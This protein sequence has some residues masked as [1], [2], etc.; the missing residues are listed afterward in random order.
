MPC[1]P[2]LRQP[3]KALPLLLALLLSSSLLCSNAAADQLR[4]KGVLFRDGDSVVRLLQH[5]GRPLWISQLGD[6]CVSR[7]DRRYYRHHARR[8]RHSYDSCRYRRPAE[9]WTYIDTGKEIRVT[10]IDD[11]IDAID[12]KFKGHSW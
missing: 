6:R 8:G 11:T 2:A 10:I 5:A 1:H 4:I 3:A 9:R 12:W 7:G